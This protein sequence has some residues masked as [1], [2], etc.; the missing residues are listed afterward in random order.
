MHEFK[1]NDQGFSFEGI[2]VTCRFD[3]Q[4]NMILGHFRLNGKGIRLLQSHQKI[5]NNTCTQNIARQKK[6][7]ET[8]SNQ[9]ARWSGVQEIHR[10]LT[11]RP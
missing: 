9:E 3:I 2:C 5:K 4:L 11:A 7:R 10:T 1:G 6:K 8:R